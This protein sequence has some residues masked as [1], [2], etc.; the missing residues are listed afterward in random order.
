MQNFFSFFLHYE[1]AEGY[2]ADDLAEYEKAALENY[3]VK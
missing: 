3:F 1:R 2:F